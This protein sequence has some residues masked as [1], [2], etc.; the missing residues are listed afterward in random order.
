MG[1]AVGLAVGGLVGD[2]VGGLVL[3]AKVSEWLGLEVGEDVSG[4]FSAEVQ[5]DRKE[6][7]T[8][9][10]TENLICFT[11]LIPIGKIW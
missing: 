11:F 7:A 4:F 2:V 3:G 1:L 8:L 5:K 10:A 9:Q 6:M